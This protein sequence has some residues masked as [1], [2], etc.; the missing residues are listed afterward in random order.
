MRKL[1]QFGGTAAAVLDAED[2][3]GSRP[4]VPGLRVVADA[5]RP[6]RELVDDYAD[7]ADTE[8]YLRASGRNRRIRRG[9]I[10]KTRNG[11]IAAG[12][13]TLLA[14][15]AIA[16]GG[17]ATVRFMTTNE[18]FRMTSSQN[19]EL[20]GNSHLSRAQMLSV[21]G[22]DVDGNVFRV[23][24]E[25][26]RMQLE[27]M[28]WVE[29]AT[30]MRL[31]PNRM[32]VHVIERVPVAFVRQGSNIG[33]VDRSGVLLDIPPDAPGNPSYS[34]PVV[35]GLKAEQEPEARAQRMRLY[36]AFLKDLDSDGK[37]TSA[38]LSEIDLSDPEDVKALI[39]DHN[40]EVLV[41]FGTEN[42]LSRYKQFE[43]HIAEWRSQYAR[44][45]SVDMRY[46][47]QV[48]LQMPPKDS[49]VGGSTGAPDPVAQKTDATSASPAA[50]P[51]VQAKAAPLTVAPKAFA[52]TVPTKATPSVSK[53]AAPKH[54]ALKSSAKTVHTAAKPATRSTKN[55]AATHKR[56]EAIKAWM[57]KRHAAQAA[58]N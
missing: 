51:P 53:S 54:T 57:A 39:P 34:F 22:E 37:S 56:V 36:A 52:A 35:T 26:R 19:I 17:Y 25:Q 3:A 4:E 49:T 12:V 15:G 58:G 8:A 41:H 18:K 21:F 9:L 32:R 33:L 16:A 46:E 1:H 40:S 24:M 31:L 2:D 11:W 44:L 5:P 47:R 48:V 42:F 20:D 28:P 45:S 23:P 30:V 13:G 55:D 50:K 14:L 27:Q 10:P 43:E 29:H 38:Q 7:D 6:R